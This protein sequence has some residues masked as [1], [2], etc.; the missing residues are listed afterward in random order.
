MKFLLLLSLF[1]VSSCGTLTATLNDH[2]Y[3]ALKIDPKAP[4]IWSKIGTKEYQEEFARTVCENG[5]IKQEACEDKFTEMFAEMLIERY[6]AAPTWAVSKYCR[7]NPVECKGLGNYEKA[8]I[9]VHNKEVDDFK[10]SFSGLL[11]EG[12]IE[13]EW[14]LRISMLNGAKYTPQPR[15]EYRPVY[16]QPVYQN[17]NYIPPMQRSPSHCESR[18]IAGTTFTDCQ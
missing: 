15:V 17:P 10:R 18:S 4:T 5:T 1:T 11:Y 16:Q 7:M 13:T 6:P 2:N 12:E 3:E 14:K 8:H 9:T